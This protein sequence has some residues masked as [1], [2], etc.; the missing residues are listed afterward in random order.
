MPLLAGRA[1]ADVAHG[2]DRLAGAASGDEHRATG[3]IAVSERDLDRSDDGR[4]LRQS[5]VTHIATGESAGLG[6]HDQHA[7]IGED[8]E[9]LL[10]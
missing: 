6:R 8:V 10:D 5:T 1:V 2:V 4:W 9:V 3:E 7:P